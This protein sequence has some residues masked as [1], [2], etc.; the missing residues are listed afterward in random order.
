VPI[1]RCTTRLPLNM[2]VAHAAQSTLESPAIAPS[3][4][5][6]TRSGVDSRSDLNL[7]CAPQAVWARR[8]ASSSIGGGDF[9]LSRIQQRLGLGLSELMVAQLAVV[10]LRES[11][12]VELV[13]RERGG[14]T[15]L[16][17][18]LDG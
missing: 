18:D 1:P 11:G 14:V 9:L 2:P 8:I 10:R 3:P 16:G 13:G 7:W 15:R 17:E 4:G 5:G 12:E 6:H